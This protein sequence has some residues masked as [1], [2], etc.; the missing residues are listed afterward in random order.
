M[1]GSVPPC[2]WGVAPLKIGRV[3]RVGPG[4]LPG[5]SNGSHLSN[6]SVFGEIDRMNRSTCCHLFIGCLVLAPP[7]AIRSAEGANPT[8]EDALQF[9]PVQAGVDISVPSPAEIDRCKIRA[10]KEKGK[11]G[12]VIEDPSGNVL[13]V[14]LDTNGDNV[15]D[16]WSYYKD[17]LEVYRDVDRNSNRKAD[18]FCWYHTAGSR[19]GLDQNEDGIIDAW[20]AI[21]A[22]EVTAEVVSALA[23]KDAARFARLVLTADELKSL[24]LG[25]ARLKELTEKIGEIK[26]RFQQLAGRQDAVTADTR[27]VQFSGN[28]PG[29]V[30][31][32]TDGATE[33]IRVYE[34]VTA[35]V[36]TGQQHGQVLIGT[37]IQ[38]GDVW[39]VID[40][41]TIPSSNQDQISSS[42]FFFK[43]LQAEQAPAMTAAVDEESQKLINEMQ[44]MDALLAQASTSGELAKL[45][46]RHAKIIE[47]LASKATIEKDRAMWIRQLADVVSAAVQSGNYPAGIKQLESLFQSLVEHKEDRD[48]AGYIKFRYMTANYFLSMSIDDPPAD[49]FMK[50]QAEWLKQLEQY[51]KEFPAV[52]DAAEAMLQLAYARELGGEE[53][54][55]GKW[56]SRIVKGFPESPVA[57]KAA[58]AQTRLDSVG[59]TL[60]LKGQSPSGQLIDLSKYRGQVVLIQYWATWCRPCK[61]DM[62]TLKDLVSRYGKSGFNI[63]GVNLDSNAQEME[64]YIKEYQVSWPQIYEEGGLDSRPA[65]ELGILTLPTMIL[66]DKEGKVVNRN[67]RVAEIDGELK[68]LIR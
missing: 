66:V 54:E 18:Q 7:L 40:L 24:G 50:V 55:A 16:R 46:A 59:K 3:A 60:A 29:I 62:P 19:V 35:V 21:S 49:H 61:A 37:L 6:D 36:Q 33:D 53:E 22:E 12:W 34:N 45:H 2:Y 20:A 13:R 11:S 57:K 68:R 30:P 41:P 43:S 23:D 32:G 38:V 42:G 65:N 14:F 48:L 15:V 39:R 52:D 47:Q 26:A 31:S 27:W 4:R 10:R 8:A 67:I 17:G 63:V 64:A 28:R 25:P 51:V 1:T 9:A 5:E 56:Y 58:G 44:G